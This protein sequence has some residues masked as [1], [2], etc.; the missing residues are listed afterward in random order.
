MLTARKGLF[1]GPGAVRHGSPLLAGGDV[2]VS[3]H[4]PMHEP[5]NELRPGEGL[6]PATVAVIRPEAL[7]HA[8]LRT[9]LTELNVVG[10]FGL[11]THLLA[12]VPRQRRS[13]GPVG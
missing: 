13:S 7:E 2:Q 8:G 11:A 1:T 12:G 10:G 5:L 6:E 4:E 3:D 9:D